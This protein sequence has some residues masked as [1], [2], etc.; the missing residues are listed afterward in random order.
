MNK[1]ILFLWM[2]LMGASGY[3]QAQ[4]PV[5]AKTRAHHKKPPQSKN[6]KFVE[7]KNQWNK[8]VKFRAAIPSGFMFLKNDGFQYTYYDSRAIGRLHTANVPSVASRRA[9]AQQIKAHSFEVKF[10]DANPH[11]QIIA[12]ESVPETMNYFLGKDPSK[13]ATN[14]QSYHSVYYQN[15]YPSI[16]LKLYE[17]NNALKYEFIV[18][19]N[20]SPKIIQMQYNAAD[21]IRLKDGQLEIQTSLGKVIEKRPYCYQII[22]GKK[23]AVEAR[24]KLN[25]NEVSFEFPYGYNPNFALVIDPELVFSTY[26]GS[27]ADNWGNTATFDAAGNLYAGGTAFGSNFPL[28]LGAFQ[29]NYGGQ[30]DV[31]ILKF[32]AQGDRLL[33]GSFYGGQDAEVPH[34]LVVDSNDD[35]IIMGTTGSD[36][37][38]TSNTAFDQTFNNASGFP[39]VTPLAGMR[40]TSGSDIFIAKISQN[41][42]LLKAATYIGGNN[43]DGLNTSTLP[44]IKNYGDAYRGDVFV[45]GSNNIYVASTTLSTDF[46]VVNAIQPAISAGHDAVVFKM[47]SDLTTM[48]WGTYLGGNGFDGAFSIKVFKDQEVFVAGATTSTGL[49]S[50]ADALHRNNLGSD[51]G[52]IARISNNGNTLEKL[53]YLGTNSA[54][55]AFFIDLDTNS[56]VY[57]F[58]QTFGNYPVT[59]NVYSNA[60][61]RQ[62]IHKLN[63]DLS[64]TIYSTVIGSGRSE[65]DISPTAFLVNDCENVYITGWGGSI[66]HNFLP[67]GYTT[68]PMRNSSTNGLPITFDGVQQTTD[69]DDFYIAVLST[70]A[71]DLVYGTFLGSNLS[72]GEHVDGGTCRFSKNGIVYHSVCACGDGSTFPT[73]PNAYS[74]FNRSNNC[75]NAAFKFDVDILTVDFDIKDS[76]QNNVTE[77]CAPATLNFVYKGL[78]ASTFDWNINN[79]VGN[80]GNTE[81]V[82]FR[83]NQEGLFTVTLVASSPP[84]CLRTLTTTKTFRVYK[85]TLTVSLSDT[86]CL[87][88]SIPL[89]VTSGKSV[90]SYSW[91]PGAGLSDS[92]IANPV[93]SPAQTT[94][95]KVTVKDVDGC[96]TAALVTVNVLDFPTTNFVAKV[97]NECGKV[98]RVKLVPDAGEGLKHTWQMGNGEVF[99]SES[100]GGFYTYPESGSYTITYTVANSHCSATDSV[101]VTVDNRVPELPNVI[102]PNGDGKNDFFVSPYTDHKIEIYNRWGRKIFERD[103]YQNDWGTDADPGIYYYI[104]ISPEGVRCKNWLK[105]TK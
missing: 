45:D 22:Q 73:T 39:S 62:F 77:I 80:I 59:P 61:A 29:S 54:D 88:D 18:A 43:N 36:D 91:T 85:N 33:Y 16:D 46:P 72:R 101:K 55:Q 69:G 51:D 27:F 26:S 7:N 30:I 31:G 89:R 84:S 58:G 5:L 24:F 92:T 6:Y 57:A 81:S 49:P 21:N 67:N 63:K 98:P 44:R 37:L 97:L 28:T 90:V 14:V 94:D 53:T 65:P 100:G 9:Q 56:N 76:V 2:L 60:N 71:K 13:W 82:N 66:N 78:G 8:T 10:K 42:N 11:P 105:V 34:S 104:L 96:E 47:T 40:Y 17:R 15:I 75:N 74:Q 19:P 68:Q 95:Y 1:I 79:G 20:T 4:I 12:Q 103:Q 32:S 35:L 102:T 23:V 38:P 86:I 70:G 3:T 52:F 41:G 50:S 48:V 25:N 93:A 64:A 87:R 99:D 83:F